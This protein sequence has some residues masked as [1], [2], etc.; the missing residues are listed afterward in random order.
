MP[1]IVTI[2]FDFDGVIINSLDAKNSAFK[3]LFKNY[4]KKFQKKVE[5]FHNQNLGI[6]R[7]VKIKRIYQELLNKNINNKFIDK[8][9]DNFS[10]IVFKKVI[11]SRLNYGV[12]KFLK[13]KQFKYDFFIASATPDDELKSIIKN[14]RITK[15]FKNIYGTPMTKEKIIDKI[16][17]NYKYKKKELVFIGDSKHDLISSQ[18]ANIKFIGKINNN[19]NNFNQKIIYFHN[20][21][22][23]DKVLT[24][25]N[26]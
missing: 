11:K 17:K 10:K 20:F 7:Y 2:I 9:A 21:N 19:Q 15:Y 4:G 24:K 3:S 23:L 14:K 18:K 13:K 8:L 12:I 16:I 25:L 22:T 5:H 6:S 1:K 26:L